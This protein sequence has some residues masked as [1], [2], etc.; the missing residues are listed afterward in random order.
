MIGFDNDG[1]AYIIKEFYQ[2]K[3]LGSQLAEIAKKEFGNVKYIADSANPDAIEEFKKIGLN[4][5]GVK[6]MKNERE[7]NFV[8]AGIRRVSGHLQ[9]QGDKKPRLFIS[10]NCPMTI[11]EFENY[12]YP[13]NKE[14]KSPSEKPLEPFSHAMDAL[15]Y[16]LM[17]RET[18]L[19]FGSLDM[20]RPRPP[21]PG[22]PEK[23][24]EKN[25]IAFG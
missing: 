25:R 1:R 12:S 2:R 9:I 3:I 7:E 21:A 18:P 16:A 17:S 24:D 13:E 15:R 10:N 11:A 14:N 20:T 5:V 19:F 23:K 4:C 22:E 6:K 8:I